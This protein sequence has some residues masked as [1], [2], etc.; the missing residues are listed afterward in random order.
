MSRHLDVA[1]E[2]A[3]LPGLYDI[4]VVRSRGLQMRQNDVSADRDDA[5][6]VGNNLTRGRLGL[7]R[8]LELTLV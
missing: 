3:F 4:D 8:R 6:P 5:R 7:K 1:R 2:S